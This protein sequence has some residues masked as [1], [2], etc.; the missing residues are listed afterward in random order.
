MKKGL[1]ALSGVLWGMIILVPSVL[2]AD[3]V[4]FERGVG[5]VSFG[6]FTVRD[7]NPDFQTWVIGKFSAHIKTNG[8][9][10]AVGEGLVQVTGPNFGT[11]FR[12][13]P[14]PGTTTT[15]N[16]FATLFCGS[17]IPATPVPTAHDS[18]D[19]PLSPSGDF[20]IVDMLTPTPPN[21]CIDPVLLIRIF[22]PNPAD[23]RHW[24]AGG[25]V[26]KN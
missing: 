8:D 9:I 19:H 7:V 21:P 15:I 12:P 17:P 2:A 16:V 11:A 4:E 10:K 25:I 3:L 5:A 6:P 1:I 20:H 14:A 23:P 26:P 18:G 24:I 13:V 22:D